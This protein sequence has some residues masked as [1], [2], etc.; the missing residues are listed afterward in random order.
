MY[1]DLSR[2]QKVI[3][4]TVSSL[5]MVSLYTNGVN[6]AKT[7]PEYHNPIFISTIIVSYISPY[8]LNSTTTYIF[9][10]YNNKKDKPL[11]KQLKNK[12]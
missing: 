12:S 1:K 9:K 4:L 2:V 6:L 3:T 10:K 5:G 7:T 8:L 11:A